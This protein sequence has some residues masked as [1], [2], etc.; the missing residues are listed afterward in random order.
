MSAQG[1][2]FYFDARPVDVEVAESIR[3]SL[4]PY[5]PDGGGEFMRPGLAM[6]YRS[7]HVTPEDAS[8]KQPFKSKRGNVMTWDG[9]L[10][11]REEILLDL[12]R[13]LDKTDT[14]DVAL[15]M[16]VY[17]KWGSDGFGKLVG[18]WSLVVWDAQEHSIL[19][20]SDYMGV[21]PLHYY[22]KK[23]FISW[24]TTLEC[25][26]R[27]HGLYGDIDR[28]YLVGFLAAARSATV[29][30]YVGVVAVP[31]AHAVTVDATGSVRTKRFWRLGSPNVRY[32]DKRDYD[33]HLRNL[34][35]SAVGKR[36]RASGPVWAQ[37]SGGLDSSSIVC[38][39]DVLVKQGLAEAPDLRTLSFITDGSPET[40]ERRFVACVD[41][42]RGR[43]SEMIQLDD[44]FDHVECDRNW[45]TPRPARIQLTGSLQSHQ[46]IRGP[47]AV[48]RCRGRLGDG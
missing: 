16:A 48:N 46:A 5:G 43:S 25:L 30:P 22:L 7:V 18:D 27:L 9:R 28:H 15:A 40:D 45:V 19:M 4:N 29:T 12:W 1:G 38:A 17:E 39:A 23:D 14:T 35:V 21:R 13:D 31:T 37:L 2:I 24:S 3:R 11:N 41:E 33:V 34:F 20:A 6:V 10:D 36:L 26:V 42:Q 44:S 32:R 8:E 47:T